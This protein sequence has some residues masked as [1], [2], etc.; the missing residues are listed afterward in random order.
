MFLLKV[1]NGDVGVDGMIINIVGMI[2]GVVINFY[3]NGYF[4]GDFRDF[5]EVVGVCVGIYGFNVFFGYFGD[6]F[7]DLK[8]VSFNVYGVRG[9]KYFV[10]WMYYLGIKQ[11]VGQ[12]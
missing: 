4:Q 1:F 8:G 7:V 3:G 9:C 5:F 2:V 11:C 10:L 6:L 12:V